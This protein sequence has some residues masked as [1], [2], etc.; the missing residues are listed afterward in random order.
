MLSFGTVAR[1]GC[2]NE[3]V[4]RAAMSS[5]DFLMHDLPKAVRRAVRELAGV[6]YERELAAELAKMR[7]E[8]DA[9]TAGKVSPFDL[10]RTIHKFHNGIARDLYNRY[11][12]GST[13]PHAVAIAIV[14][15]TLSM[16]EVPEPARQH[17]EHWVAV[18][19]QL[20]EELG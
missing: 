19:T 11:A 9:W 13:L 12:Q 10:E 8:F 20:E 14:H 5:Y 6:A 18:F 1:S 3:G 2:G 4:P 17:L 15:G 7:S 16:D